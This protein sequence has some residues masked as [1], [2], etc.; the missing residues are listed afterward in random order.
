MKVTKFAFEDICN[1]GNF[2]LKIKL[3]LATL[4]FWREIWI[5]V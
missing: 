2:I 4:T 1:F 3:K 5:L